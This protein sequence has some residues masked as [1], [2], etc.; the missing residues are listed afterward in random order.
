[1]CTGNHDYEWIEN[2]KIFDRHS[3][4]INDYAHFDLS[5]DVIIEYYEDNSLENYVARIR[6]GNENLYLLVL[7][8]GPR[9]EVLEWADNYDREHES[10]RFILMTHEWLSSEG[11]R[12]ATDTSAELHF[13]GY[14]SYSTPEYIWNNIVKDNN[15]IVC[16]LCGHE[17]NF[18]CLYQTRNSFGRNV[19]QILFNLQFLPNGGGKWHYPNL[20]NIR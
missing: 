5:D 3:T 10:D 14:S 20:E 19:P 8:F 2:C 12:M 17:E 18:S 1:M 11:H 9:T 6:V 4:L 15:N 16:V 13:S 7:E